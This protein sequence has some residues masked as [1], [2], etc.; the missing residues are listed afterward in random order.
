MDKWLSIFTKDINGL[1][2]LPEYDTNEHVYKTETD[3]WIERADLW[4][5]RREWGRAGLGVWD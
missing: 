1:R 3:P 2:I 4:L 5:W